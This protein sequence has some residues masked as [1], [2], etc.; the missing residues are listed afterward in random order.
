M[1]EKI[2]Q[3]AVGFYEKLI[4]V[5]WP[6]YFAWLTEKMSDTEP[7]AVLSG[8]IVLVFVLVIYAWFRN[9]NA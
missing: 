9:R 6:A 2:I 8:S 3:T 1:F 4:H 7:F 5:Y